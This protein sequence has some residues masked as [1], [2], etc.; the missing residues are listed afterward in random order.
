MNSCKNC[1]TVLSG[2]YCSNCGLNSE[3]SRINGKYLWHEVQHLILFE[4]G[5]FYTVKQLLVRP[6]KTVRLFLTEDRNRIV[7]PVLF[8]IVTS[9]I[10]T[11]IAQYFHTEEE[12]VNRLDKNPSE[13][14]PLVKWVLDNYGYANMIMAV[15]IAFWVKIVFRK[16]PYNFYEILIL[17][18]YV[19]GLG[20]LF[21][22]L[23]ALT[24]G[25]FNIDLVA[26]ANIAIFAYLT[27]AIAS[28]FN[29][30]KIKNY[31]AAF[32]AYILG[33]ITFFQLIYLIGYIY[34]KII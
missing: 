9:L 19:M 23:S 31:F 27:Y 18:F 13:S 5:F 20:M 7:K 14:V 1:K 17:L 34:Q 12:Y 25:L 16:A 30:K 8:L 3:I 11:L 15:F 10:Y 6:G 4:K 32:F 29:P 28:F 26:Y 22:A 2:K 33:F 21:F 24:K